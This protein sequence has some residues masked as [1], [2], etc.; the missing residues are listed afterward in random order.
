[1]DT[2]NNSGFLL[3]VL[4]VII[5]KLAF[6]TMK[7]PRLPITYM[8]NIQMSLCGFSYSPYVCQDFSFHFNVYASF[9]RK[10]C[11]RQSIHYTINFYV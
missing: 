7:F 6:F 8:N 11:S 1:M 3:T 10:M 9:K 5:K 2:I 4:I